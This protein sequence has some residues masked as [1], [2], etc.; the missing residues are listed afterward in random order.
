MMKK[1]FPYLL[2]IG[3]ALGIGGLS[4]FLTKDSMP[5]YSAVKQPPLSPPAWVFPIIW[6]VLFI[7][8]GI[9]AAFYWCKNGN[10]FD[11]A[12][13]LYGLQ[14]VFNFCWTLIFFDFRAF[15]FAFLWLLALLLMIAGTAHL[16]SRKSRVAGRLMI[17]YLLWVTF[18]GYLNFGVFLLNP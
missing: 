2:S 8:M 6:S 14:L 10:Q 12:L 3:I 9:A 18:A 16:F 1:Y 11:K 13:F 17:P 15:F 7:L 4:A 5:F